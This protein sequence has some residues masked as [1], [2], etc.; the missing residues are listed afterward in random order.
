MN[1][2][3]VP[4]AVAGAVALALGPIR[5]T[6]PLLVS[7]SVDVPSTRTISLSVVGAQ[8]VS[9]LLV[10]GLLF[11]VAFGVGRKRADPRS[12][13]QIA[14]AAGGAAAVGSVVG[15][16]AVLAVL[17]P[18]QGAIAIVQA[19]GSAVGVGVHLGVVVFAGLALAR[20]RSDS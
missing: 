1:L 2:S 14:L 20:Y 12:D 3:A 13:G 8:L 10:Y 7:S 15:T 6:A 18:Q 19:F 16:A 17:E 11:G 5:R 9:F 4:P